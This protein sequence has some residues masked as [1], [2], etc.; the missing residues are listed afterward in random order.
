MIGRLVV[1]GVGLLGGSV[2]LAARAS[3]VARE[4]VGVGRDR[5]RLEGPLRAGLVDRIATDVAAGVDGAD[6]VVLAATVGA[7]ERLLESIWARVPAGA[8]LTDVGSTKRRIVTA[9]ERLAAGRPLAFLGSH[10]M[11]GSEKSGWQVARADLFRGATVIVTPTDA[12]EPRAIKGVS[13]L[14]EAL[15]ARVSALDPETHD[16]TVAAIS[17]L[18]HVAAWA[19]VDAVGRFE[20]GA[21]AFA[22]RGFKDMTRIAASDPPMWRDVLLDNADAIRASLGAFRAALDE[23]ERLL[24]AGDAA[25][26]EALLARL[27]TTREG[28]A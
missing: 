17:H 22:A 27:K 4:I 1:V 24:A 16:R 20:P 3:G 25:G 14:W 6:C 7:N 23:L 9:A 15:G 13:A 8:L 5:Q 28:L 11:A 18:P 21:L 2:A 10:P 12:T 19:L 26:I